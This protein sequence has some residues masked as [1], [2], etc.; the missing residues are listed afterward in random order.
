MLVQS[1]LDYRVGRLFAAA[2]RTD[3]I[4][5]KLPHTVLRWNQT[6]TCQSTSPVAGTIVRIRC[7]LFRAQLSGH[8]RQQRCLF[9]FR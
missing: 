7:R 6:I 1:L 3:R 5:K 9:P 8:I 2:P 4:E